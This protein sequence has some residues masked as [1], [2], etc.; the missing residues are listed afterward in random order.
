MVVR[1]LLCDFYGVLGGFLGVVRVL[2]ACLPGNCQG[3]LGGF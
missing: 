3:V 1:L 2:D